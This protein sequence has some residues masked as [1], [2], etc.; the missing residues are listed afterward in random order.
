M[1][2]NKRLSD[3]LRRQ[4]V[5]ATTQSA[6]APIYSI[7]NEFDLRLLVLGGQE[8]G[9]ISTSD[10]I[11]FW[12]GCRIAPDLVK[13]TW[14]LP[15]HAAVREL[16]AEVERLRDLIGSRTGLTK[17]EIA[18]AIG[19]DRRSLSGFVKGEIRPT[20]E[21]ILAL[22]ALAD[23]AVWC[24]EQFGE[25]TR[26][27][28]RGVDPETSP[29][30]LFAEG[31]T[32]VRREIRAA[33]KKTGIGQANDITT[34]P[35]NTRVPLY[36]KAAETWRGKGLAPTRQGTPRSSSVYEQDLTKASTAVQTSDRL[37]RRNI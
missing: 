1:D 16:A 30:R 35:R 22:R 34:R 28:L 9:E 15:H 33:A 36:V 4:P 2:H 14:I 8:A 11:G 13:T 25:H 27:L 12:S 5:T 32:D 29:L 20:E 37:R 26:E 24:S 19:V 6:F 17:Q 3:D 7:D 31:K 23:T 21:R 10:H 18:K